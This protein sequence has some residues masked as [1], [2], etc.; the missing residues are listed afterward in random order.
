MNTNVFEEVDMNYLGQFRPI[1]DDELELIRAWRN[2]PA[3]RENM[4]TRHEIS[5]EE[6]LAWWKKVQQSNTQKYFMYDIDDTP[7]GVVGFMNIDLLN[8]NAF[9]AFYASPD[10][11]KGVGTKMEFL[12][13]DYA[14]ESLNLHKLSCEV[15]AFNTSVIKLHK[16]FGFSVEG[17]LRDQHKKDD[18]FCDVYQL[19]LLNSEW[20][21][22]RPNMK[23]KLERL[24]RN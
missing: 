17:I 19:G 11:K 14:F 2:A 16:K 6:H 18:E 23:H 15:L 4:Y 24:N 5:V 8:R 12:A 13:I 3:V 10:A 1:C 21:E 22:Q 7:L 9:W 20:C